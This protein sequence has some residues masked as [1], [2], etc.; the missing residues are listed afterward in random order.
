[1]WPA[2]I[3]FLDILSV[4]LKV[5][6]SVW[7]HVESIGLAFLLWAGIVVGPLPCSTPRHWFLSQLQSG[8]LAGLIFSLNGFS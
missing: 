5:W 8:C 3:F 2:Q 6:V 7:L 4:G 1:M